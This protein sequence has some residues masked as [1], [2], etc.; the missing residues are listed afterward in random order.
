MADEIMNKKS[1]NSTLFIIAFILSSLLIFLPMLY[2]II[3]I[4][5]EKGLV[6][7]CIGIILTTILF[8]AIFIYIVFIILSIK[9]SKKDLHGEPDF[10]LMVFDIIPY[11]LLTYMVVIYGGITSFYYI[12]VLSLKF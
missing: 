5:K 2:I 6:S 10:L 12:I 11:I 8:I 7:H 4:L 3:T 9:S 1:N